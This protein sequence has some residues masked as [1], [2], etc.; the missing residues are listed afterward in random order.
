MRPVGST[1]LEDC[2]VSEDLLKRLLE[3]TLSAVSDVGDQLPERQRA[4]LAVYCYRRSH[5]RK[6]GLSLASHCSKQAMILEAG[7][8]GEMIHMQATDDKKALEI[9]RQSTPKG[10]K[11][12]VSLYVV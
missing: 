7:H 8:A 3:A 6:L 12:P 5:F 9:E 4:A 1:D 10:G 2:P 11:A